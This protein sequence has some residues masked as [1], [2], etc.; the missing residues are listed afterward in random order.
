MILLGYDHAGLFKLLFIWKWAEIVIVKTGTST[1]PGT[2]N[3]GMTK[4]GMTQPG[5]TKP[6]AT[7]LRMPLSQE[8]PNEEQQ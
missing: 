4:P 2:T 1:E 7:S 3:P 6:G 5:M 8:R